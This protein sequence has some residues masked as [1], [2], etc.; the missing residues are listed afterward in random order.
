M[1]RTAPEEVNLAA[2]AHEQ[3][4]K[5]AEFVRTFMSQEFPGGQLVKRLEHESS[6][7]TERS[8]KKV[9]PVR[10]AAVG[11]API[12]VQNFEDLYGFRGDDPRVYYLSPWEF[13]M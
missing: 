3:D 5:N 9:V 12:Y 4:V 7:E 11:Q 8:V 6:E 10:K 2:N 13:L 1:L